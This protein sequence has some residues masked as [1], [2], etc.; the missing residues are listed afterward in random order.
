MCPRMLCMNCWQVLMGRSGSHV[1]LL[2]FLFLFFL[3]M[4]HGW[5]I[6]NVNI[7]VVF[8]LFFIRLQTEIF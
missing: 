3:Y 6:M 8:L 1:I 5:F 2:S 4:G 7:Q